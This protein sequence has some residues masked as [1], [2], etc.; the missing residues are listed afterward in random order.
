MDANPV[1]AEHLGN[2]Y[3]PGNESKRQHRFTQCDSCFYLPANRLTEMGLFADQACD[4][5]RDGDLL[6]YHC[7]PVCAEPIPHCAV[8]ERQFRAFLPSEPP[9]AS[10][11][12]FIF[13]RI[14]KENLRRT[15]HS[16]HSRS[17]CGS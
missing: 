1:I 9:K 14:R 13:S 17:S 11:V 10:C 2:N 12:L 15:C 7:T 6:L 5:I 3:R 16:V 4:D 8:L